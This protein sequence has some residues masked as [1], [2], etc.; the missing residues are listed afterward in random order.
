M[1]THEI[2]LRTPTVGRKHKYLSLFVER[3][4]EITPHSCKKPLN[5]M[6][7]KYTSHCHEPRHGHVHPN[8]A[9]QRLYKNYVQSIQWRKSELISKH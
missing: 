4:L 3:A 1:E 2:S 5:S 6:G 7:G 8:K 9:C